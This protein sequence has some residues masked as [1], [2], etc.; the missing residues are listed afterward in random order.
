MDVDRARKRNAL[1]R[2][3]LLMHPVSRKPR[4][5]RPDQCQQTYDEAQPNH[6]L[7]LT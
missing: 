1:D 2:E 5:Q 6:S 7:T 3:L 4:E